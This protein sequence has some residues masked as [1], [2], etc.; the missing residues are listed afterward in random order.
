MAEVE[1]SLF[2]TGQQAVKQNYPSYAPSIP[3]QSSLASDIVCVNVNYK[4]SD[5]RA[6][7]SSFAY[8]ITEQEER[9]ALPAHVST[10][11]WKRSG[12]KIIIGKLWHSIM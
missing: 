6:G 9:E 8:I 7:T 12:I 10:A 4:V 2:Y 1:H 3:P 11:H 5:C